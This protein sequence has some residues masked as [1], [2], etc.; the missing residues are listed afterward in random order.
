MIRRTK[1]KMVRNTKPKKTKLTRRTAPKTKLV[2]RT[3]PPLKKVAMTRRTN[4]HTEPLAPPG[5]YKPASPG[6]SHA[7]V[8]YSSKTGKVQ[9]NGQRWADNTICR[10]ICTNKCSLYIKRMKKGK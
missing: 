8:F 4:P 6:C 2:R 7:H 5:G 3:T 1:Q 10:Y 9:Y